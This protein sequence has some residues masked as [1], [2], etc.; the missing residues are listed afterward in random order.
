M[1][2]NRV[3][4]DNYEDYKIAQEDYCEQMEHYAREDREEATRKAMQDFNSI[5]FTGTEFLNN[6]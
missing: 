4:F 3:D 5:S 6:E 1:N 2:I